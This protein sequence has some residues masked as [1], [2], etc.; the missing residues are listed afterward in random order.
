MLSPTVVMLKLKRDEL[1]HHVPV[2]GEMA[3]VK[4]IRI[5]YCLSATERGAVPV[6]PIETQ[7]AWSF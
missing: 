4:E 7:P 5:L 1:Q 2:A 6:L 3:S